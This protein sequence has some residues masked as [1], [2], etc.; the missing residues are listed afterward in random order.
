MNIIKFLNENDILYFP[1]RLKDKKPLYMKEYKKTPSYNDFKTLKREEIIKRHQYINSCGYLWIDTN[2]IYQ[3]DLDRD[4]DNKNNETLEI[5]KNYPYYKS[6]SKAYG[7]HIFIKDE[8]FK[9]ININLSRAKNE[10]KYGLYINNEFIEDGGEILHGQGAYCKIDE[11]VYNHDKPLIYDNLNSFI[12]SKKEI[13][14]ID[15][16]SE[17]LNEILNVN[18]KWSYTHDKEYNI[19]FITNDNN[20]CFSCDKIHDNEKQNTLIISL[21]KAYFKCYGLGDDLKLK[22]TS[23]QLKPLRNIIKPDNNKKNENEKAKYILDEKLQT[24]YNKLDEKYKININY[25]DIENFN[26]TEI[27]ICNLF[28]KLNPNIGLIPHTKNKK[29]NEWYIY[30]NGQ[31]TLSTNS[32]IQL[33]I[34]N[35]LSCNLINVKYEVLKNINDYDITNKNDFL[36]NIIKI[37]NKLLL[38]INTLRYLKS[39]CET[40]IMIYEIQDYEQLFNSNLHLLGFGDYVYDLNKFLFRKAKKEDYITVKVGITY[41]EFKTENKENEKLYIDFM[42]S[43]FPDIQRLK[44]IIDNLTMNLN[45]LRTEDAFYVNIG[46]GGNGKGKIC[47]IIKYGFGEYAIEISPSIF[48]QKEVKIGATNTELYNTLYKRLVICNEPEQGAK[49]NNSFLKRISGGDSIHARPLY[50]DGVAFIPQYSVYLNVNSCEFQDNKDNSLFRRLRMNNFTQEFKDPE[51]IIN[52]NYQKP[53]KTIYNDKEILKKISIELMK[54][55]IKN[56]EKIYNPIE[57]KYNIETPEFIKKEISELLDENDIVK[58]FINE[59]LDFTY[60]KS[61]YKTLKDIYNALNNYKQENGIYDKITQ[62]ELRKRLL[63]YIKNT[64]YYSDRAVVINE[65]G[66]KQQKRSIYYGVIFKTETDEEIIE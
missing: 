28:K 13:K 62:K 59:E 7:K 34:N 43:I 14:I 24:E 60:D 50:G 18:Y 6:V 30:K 38:K 26:D 42:T 64:D 5:V 39:L 33:L 49:F 41:D 2:N 10:G 22:A 46:N 56:H 19:L 25:K 27:Y 54:D 4:I 23:K 58:Q 15:D 40:L 63:P 66:N 3:I 35:T 11:I 47:L 12:T 45:G 57:K 55:L 51:D 61:K 37:I 53:K 8:E 17:I 29:S 20:Y 21:K 16:V 48:T 36:N 1:L 65:Y 32:K 44:Y 31:W 9:K 52:S